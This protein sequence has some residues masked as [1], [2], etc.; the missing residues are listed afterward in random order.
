ME[1]PAVTPQERNAIR[2]LDAGQVRAAE[3]MA[4][5][6]R[7]P[8]YTRLLDDLMDLRTREEIAG[9][10]MSGDRFDGLG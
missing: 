3:L 5:D 7:H 10:R 1:T 2:K 9:D 8:G 6:D 4:R